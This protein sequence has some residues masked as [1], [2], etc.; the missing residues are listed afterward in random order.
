[1]GNHFRMLRPARLSY[2][3]RGLLA[4]LVVAA[5][6]STARGIW[7][8]SQ[9][10]K[11]FQ[12]SPTVLLLDGENPY[13]VY[14]NGDPDSAL[15]KA[16]TP[17]YA[18]AMYLML[19]PFGLMDWGVAKI[20]WALLNV[21][22]GFLIV[23]ILSE[24]LKLSKDKTLFVFLTFFASNSF[25]IGLGNGQHG[26]IMLLAF[27]VI[28]VSRKYWSSFTAGIGYFKY[29]FAPPFAAYLFFRRG[30]F[31][32]FA[33]LLPGITGFFV[34]WIITGG[35][36]WETLT[37]PLLVSS[38]GVA[39]GSAD[40]M[41][42]AEKL[43]NEGSIYHY[44]GY[45]LLPILLSLCGAYYASKKIIEKS[46]SFAFLCLIS[47]VSFKHLSYDFVFLLPAFAVA[48]KNIKNISSK[49]VISVILFVWFGWKVVYEITSRV[50]ALDWLLVLRSPY[51]NLFLMLSIVVAIPFASTVT[52]SKEETPT[53]VS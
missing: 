22:V 26:L 24:L 44:I 37:Q 3:K 49:Y 27:L 15:I 50:S 19:T 1:M 43:T 8:A 9:V 25:R 28:P 36:F 12:W 33:S 23:L 46:S 41:T 20:A 53:D 34:F 14:L 10:S 42:I 48:I 6:A 45:Y 5:V 18:H 21:A 38:Q 52:K 39:L 11:D 2:L 32:F 51:L 4:L 29:S 17:N 7:N 40:I 13:E 47:L 35:P 31:Q 30:T 16:Q